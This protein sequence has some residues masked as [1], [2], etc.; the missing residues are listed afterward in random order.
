MAGE[1]PEDWFNRAIQPRCNICGRFA[2]WDA[3]AERWK[4]ACVFYSEEV[5]YEHN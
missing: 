2:Y 5:G 3:L 4:L 1:N